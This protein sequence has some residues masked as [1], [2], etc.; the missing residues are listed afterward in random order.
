VSIRQQPGQVIEQVEE[1]VTHCPVD[2]SHVAFDATQLVH[3]RPP[4]PHALSVW[5]VMHVV[6]AQHPLQLPGPHG[7]LTHALDV[8]SHN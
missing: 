7:G 2:E 3:A 1:V 4:M 8:G 6:P 5:V